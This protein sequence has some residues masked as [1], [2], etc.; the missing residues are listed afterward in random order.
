M[1][2]G[3]VYS[4]FLSYGDS[5][6]GSRGR[7]VHWRAV[8][9]CTEI[10]RRWCDLTSETWDLEQG[11]HARVRAVGRRESSK[12]AMTRRRFDPKSDSKLK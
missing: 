7:R 12:W 9:H 6:E 3:T 11:Y 1:T 10:V 4:V 8:W 2:S 5:V